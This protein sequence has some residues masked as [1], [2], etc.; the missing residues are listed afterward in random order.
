MNN[1]YWD[2]LIEGLKLEKRV[3]WLEIISRWVVYVLVLGLLLTL[4]TL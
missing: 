4:I 2:E 3:Y 1:E